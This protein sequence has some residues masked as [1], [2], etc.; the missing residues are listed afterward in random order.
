MEECYLIDE[1]YYV[2]HVLQHVL[3]GYRLKMEVYKQASCM[4]FTGRYY[5][6]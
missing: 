6:G 3:L 1:L 5:L 2:L 4:M